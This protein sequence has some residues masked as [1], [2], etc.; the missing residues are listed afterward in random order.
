MLETILERCSKTGTLLVLDECF[1]DFLDEPE[2]YTLKDK[3][4]ENK[5]L[6]ILKAFTKL[7]GMAGI[8]LGY[9]L[10]GDGELIEKMREAGQ[11]WGV[12]SLAQEAGIAALSE[13]EYV[14]RTKA[15]IK[16]ERKRLKE[17]LS[18]LGAEVFGGEANYIFLKCKVYD[19]A[20]KMRSEGVL[21]RD[22]SNYCGLEKG[23][24]RVAVRT[25]EENN[26]LLET[27]EK[28]IK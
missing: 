28:V 22:C 13:K 14:V 15:L 21:I 1:N 11:P 5:N 3:I 9:C 12:S 16:E 18:E 19:L 7:Y 17:A 27:L 8:R 26:R 23:Y 2:R 25:R 24:F 6:I 10:C 20:T 4:K